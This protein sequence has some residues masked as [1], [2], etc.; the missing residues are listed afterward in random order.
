MNWA[1]KTCC[2]CTI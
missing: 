2:F 1:N